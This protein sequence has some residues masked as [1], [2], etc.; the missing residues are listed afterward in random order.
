MGFS[1]ERVLL[2]VF[3]TTWMLQ[4][5]ATDWNLVLLNFLHNLLLDRKEVVHFYE[6]Y[7]IWKSWIIGSRRSAYS[8]KLKKAQCLLCYM[9]RALILG[10]D[11][12]FWL[13][14]MNTLLPLWLCVSIS[15]RVTPQPPMNVPSAP[16][17]NF[18][19]SSGL[20]TWQLP[21]LKHD[22]LLTVETLVC[23]M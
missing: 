15:L 19:S 8:D 11:Q 18:S 7:R 6:Y 14:S 22:S 16:T 13:L 2:L 1:L 23:K 5:M 12:T 21:S 20:H 10:K 9:V 17:D 3:Q 4:L